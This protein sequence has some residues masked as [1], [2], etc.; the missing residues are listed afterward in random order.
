[1][2]ENS[3]IMPPIDPQDPGN[4]EDSLTFQ[5]KSTEDVLKNRNLNPKPNA[6]QRLL[7]RVGLAGGA[8]IAAGALVGAAQQGVFDEGISDKN[9]NESHSSSL[10]KKPNTFIGEPVRN[11]VA[12]DMYGNSIPVHGSASVEGEDEP[13]KLSY[14]VIPNSTE[15]IVGFF[16]ASTDGESVNIADYN[17]NI[18]QPLPAHPVQGEANEFG[19]EISTNENGAEEKKSNYWKI[20]GKNQEGKETPLYITWNSLAV[21]EP[22]PVVIPQ[23]QNTGY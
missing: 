12:I 4:R 10:E 6:I 8:A 13:Q 7:N 21:N 9:T 3:E 2:S 22:H 14:M 19:Q 16:N 11:A 20:V 5:M 1:M 15:N 17:I 18:K 23:N